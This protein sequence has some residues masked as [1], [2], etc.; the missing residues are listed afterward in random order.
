MFSRRILFI[1]TTKL[2]Q[3]QRLPFSGY[4]QQTDFSELGQSKIRIIETINIKKSLIK[5]EFGTRD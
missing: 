4:I 5:R 1:L 2:N 3:D